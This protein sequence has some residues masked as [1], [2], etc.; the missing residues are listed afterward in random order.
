MAGD[1]HQAEN[2]RLLPETQERWRRWG[3]YLSERQWGTV[4]EDYSPEGRVWEYFPH[5]HARSRAYRWGEDGLLGWCDREC[6][7]C[8]AVALWN[9][10]DPILKERLFGLTNL[11]GNHGE[12]VKELYYYLDATPTASY[13]R[14][15]YKLPQNPFPYNLLVD[16]SRS[17]RRRDREL[18]LIDTG[19][20]DE[21]C[22]FDVFVEYAKAGEDDTL[23]RITV[24]NRSPLPATIHLLPT[25]WFRNTWSWGSREEGG[26]AKPRIWQSGPAEVCT[27]HATLE[28]MR[29]IADDTAHASRLGLLFTENQTN[30]QRLY[31][32]PG[33]SPYTKDAFHRYLIQNQ[34]DAVNHQQEGTKAAVH[35][36]LV[37]PGRQQRAVRLR[38]CPKSQQVDDALGADFEDVFQQRIAEAD[39]FYEQHIPRELDPERRRVMRQAYAGLLWSSQ[40]YH[41]VVDDW[42]EGDQKLPPP[43]EQRLL[44]RNSAWRH[45]HNRHVIS[46]PDKW[47]YPWYSAWDLGFHAIPLAAIDPQLAREQLLLLLSDG[48][49]HPGGQL[50][51]YEFDFGDVNPPVHAWAC[52]RVYQMEA[53]NGRRDRA[54]LASA[55][56]KLLVNWQWWLDRRDSSG[57]TLLSG[58]F[59]GMDHIGVFDRRQLMNGGRLEQTDAAAWAAFYCATMLRIALE[60]AGDDDRCEETALRLL[61]QFVAISDAIER[62]GLWNDEDGFYYD[63]LQ[64]GQERAALRLRAM[65]GLVP[66]LAVQVLDPELLGPLKRFRERLQVLHETRRHGVQH[67]IRQG[68]GRSDGH[69]VLLALS[70]R[71]RLERVL[72]YLLDVKEFLAPF[73]IRSLSAIYRDR[74]SRFDLGGCEHIV[75]YEPG[76]AEGDL[77]GGNVN[78]RGPIWFPLNY[79]LIESLQA[80]QRFYGEDL[81]VEF[82]TGSGQRMNLEQVARQIS[83]R[84]CAIF[85]PD[86][87]GRRPC[88]N[89]DLRYI[90]DPH[91]RDL[92]LFYEFF[93][94]DTGR[95]LGA[96]H[97]TGWTALVTQLLP[98]GGE[99][100]QRESEAPRGGQRARAGARRGR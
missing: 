34:V 13:A 8:F 17:R 57:R 78:W 2:G 35:Y 70:S 45:L 30:A 100:A 96:S 12:D 1:V 40:F 21:S 33:T 88:H 86:D 9:G 18:E 66:L 41:F 52:W 31:R 93:H 36:E 61:D 25:L 97:Q 4:R 98:Q 3:T 81:R 73:G 94:G 67:A 37:I 39:A 63:C 84:L 53:A 55:F 83:Q 79:L 6:R 14:A 43:P 59:P 51:A 20:F 87:E 91:F 95:G 16:A 90:I 58:G 92:V 74:P 32:A 19:V 11:E 38:L 27:E 68:K 47:E 71:Q 5:D 64:L 42:L 82:P 72:G 54:F 60:L 76:P 77:F 22:Y 85:L 23:I 24:A 44:G 26:W 69:T 89:D 50:P 99:Q 46:M 65:A 56:A 29:L 49:M 10:R 75:R 15:L 62:V 48:Y 7:L 28:P 80:Y